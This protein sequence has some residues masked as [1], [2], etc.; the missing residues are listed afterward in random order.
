MLQARRS[1]NHQYKFLVVK[2]DHLAAQWAI[3]E[4]VH[5]QPGTASMF[6]PS[7]AFRNSKMRY[8]PCP[9][10]SIIVNPPPLQNFRFVFGS[11]FST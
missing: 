10:N 6:Y 3:P 11:T 2:D 9:Q 5:T 8:P 4:N 7:L 1:L